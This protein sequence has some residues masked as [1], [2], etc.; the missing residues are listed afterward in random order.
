M[1]HLH[2]NLDCANGELRYFL[3][4][5]FD[6][7]LLAK[8][9]ELKKLTVTV[10]TS[11][12]PSQ[13]QYKLLLK[14]LFCSL[15]QSQE[16]RCNLKKIDTELSVLTMQWAETLEEHKPQRRRN[17]SQTQEKREKAGKYDKEI[18]EKQVSR[19]FSGY[20]SFEDEGHKLLVK[21]ILRNW[22]LS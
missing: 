3:P 5:D 12:D 17:A 15:L 19:I 2:G 7:F 11:V 21:C 18:G 20:C 16:N 14:S 13:T 8:Q 4:Y 10:C 22:T 6:R 1:T 9:V